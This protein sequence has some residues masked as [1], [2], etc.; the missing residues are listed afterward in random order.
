[1]KPE[2]KIS[3]IQSQIINKVKQ[4]F[5]TLCEKHSYHVEYTPKFLRTVT[6]M[7][8]NDVKTFK[9]SRYKIVTHVTILKKVLGQSVY[10]ISKAVWNSND[11]QKICIRSDNKTFIAVCLI[12]LIYRE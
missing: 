10:F 5:E 11:D 9:L 3:L 7:I 4:T 1:M 8:K 2:I 12:Y 6:E